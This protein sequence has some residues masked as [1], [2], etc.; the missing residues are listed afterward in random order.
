MM[1]YFEEEFIEQVDKIKKSGILVIVEGKKDK[2][3]LE[4]FGVTNIITLSK[5]PLFEVIEEI[6]S[7][8]KDCIILTDLDKTGKELYSKLNHG[9]QQFGVKVNNNFRNFLLKRTKLSHV[10]GLESYM[11]KD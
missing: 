9:L 1:K 11:E 8:N 10:E 4:S 2:K 7:K 3:A 6:S 5:K